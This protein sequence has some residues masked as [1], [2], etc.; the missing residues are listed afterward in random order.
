MRWRP[1]RWR[2]GKV[3]GS[4]RPPPTIGGSTCLLTARRPGRTRRVREARRGAADPRP[5]RARD[6]GR[7]ARERRRRGDRV[8]VRERVAAQPV[9]GPPGEPARRRTCRP[10][11]SCP[12]TATAGAATSN[13]PNAPWTAAPSP[14]RVTRLTAGPRSSSVSPGASQSRSS[15]E[16]LTTSLR[17]STRVEARAVPRLVGD[18]RGT[19]VRVDHDQRA[20]RE[21]IASA[22]PP[23][24][25]IGSS[26]SA[27]RPDVRGP[28]RR[29]VRR[30][31]RPGAD[32]PSV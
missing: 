18:R 21:P 1:C 19:D 28:P 9:L 32:V 13:E 11:R 8:A 3:E 4:P 29:R 26:T 17:A 2:A 12:S 25:A 20:A 27:E 23:P 16:T 5:A 15:S 30:P 6:R 24:S 31:A 22:P 7:A 10:P 14:P